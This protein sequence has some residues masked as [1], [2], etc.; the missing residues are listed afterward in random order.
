MDRSRTS[1]KINNIIFS[2]TKL[3]IISLGMERDE[4]K[5][6]RRKNSRFNLL[7]KEK[8]KKDKIT[9]VKVIDLFAFSYICRPE[10]SY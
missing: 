7:I 10:E 1:D 5:A 4:K 6:S 3:S 9:N 8:E 2:Y